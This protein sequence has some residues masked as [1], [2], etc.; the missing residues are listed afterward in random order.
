MSKYPLLILCAVF[1][2]FSAV[3]PTFAANYYTYINGGN[4]GNW[5]D[6]N[7]WTT[8]PSG[9]TLVGSAVPASGDQV[10]ILN[11]YTVTLTDNVAETALRITIQ[12]GGTLDLSTYTLGAPV[13]SLSGGG[14]LKIKSGY[15]PTVT[16]NNFQNSNAS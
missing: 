3:T 12:N 8:D 15:F 5:N 4:S 10:V 9:V 1:S 7:I 11:G 13:A 16:T 2:F 6:P 14:T